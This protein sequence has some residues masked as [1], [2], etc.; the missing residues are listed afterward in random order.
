VRRLIEALE[1]QHAWERA[2]AVIVCGDINEWFTIGRP[3]RWLHGRLG[4]TPAL[5]TFP[6]GF[7][8]FALDRIWVQP[9]AAVLG[10]GVHATPAARAASD[11]LP[12]AAEIEVPSS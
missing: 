6:A 5:P 10:L 12:L 7:P 3:L 8:M 4:R 1:A 11:H 9:R 2:A